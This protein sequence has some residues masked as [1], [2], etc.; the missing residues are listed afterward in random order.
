MM[1]K[2]LKKIWELY[3]AG[4]KANDIPISKYGFFGRKGI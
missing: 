3:M 2:W 1:K 4:A